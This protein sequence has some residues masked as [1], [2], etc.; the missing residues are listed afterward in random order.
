M[1]K[2][3]NTTLITLVIILIVGIIAYPKIKPLLAQNQ[4]GSGKGNTGALSARQI[5]NVSGFLIKPANLSE[6]LS[7]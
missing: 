3:V 2:K 6:L 1:N 5:L 4:K 7:Q